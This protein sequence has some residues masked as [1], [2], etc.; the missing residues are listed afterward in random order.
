MWK[1]YRAFLWATFV[2]KD[3]ITMPELAAEP[4]TASGARSIL[5][6]CHAGSCAAVI[7]SKA[8]PAGGQGLALRR[9]PRKG[10]S[11]RPMRLV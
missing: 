2:E 5:R 11:G 8:L 1:A 10:K 6:C 3:D 9:S 7:D 4:E